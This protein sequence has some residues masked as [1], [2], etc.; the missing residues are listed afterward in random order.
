MNWLSIRPQRIFYREGVACCCHNAA[1][2]EELEE[3]LMQLAKCNYRLFTILLMP[4]LLANFKR[5]PRH[6]HEP[7]SEGGVLKVSCPTSLNLSGKV[8]HFAQPTC[9]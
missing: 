4:F 9:F 6:A 8:T 2:N 5:D 1:I 7:D 3:R